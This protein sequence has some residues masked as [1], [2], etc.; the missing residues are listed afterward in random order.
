MESQR[1]EADFR[2]HEGNTQT[3][4]N[5]ALSRPSSE[6][7]WSD[8]L[9]PVECH[10]NAATMAMIKHRFGVL[11][12]EDDCVLEELDDCE[13]PVRWLL[14]LNGTEVEVAVPPKPDDVR[15]Y[16]RYDR[17]SALRRATLATL[18]RLGLMEQTNVK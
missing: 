17:R 1:A 11:P 4:A 8:K 2:A 18:E 7:Q 10:W 16:T 6:E 14:I 3:L 9:R 12:G 13:L 5:L 15:Y